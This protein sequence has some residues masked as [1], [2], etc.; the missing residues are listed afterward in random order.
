[1]IDDETLY[2]YLDGELDAADIARVEKAVAGDPGLAEKLAAQRAL[3]D[4]LKGAFDPIAEQPVPAAL[5]ASAAPAAAHVVDLAGVRRARTGAA[6]WDVRTWGA[7]AATL[8][9]GLIGGYAMHMMPAA[10]VTESD[11]RLVLS[12]PIARALDEQLASTGPSAGPVQVRLTF[13]DT[14]G[15]ICRSFEATSVSGVACRHDGRWTMR[16]LFEGSDT[17]AGP[18][19]TA[20]AADPALMEYVDGIIAGEPFDAASEARA[21]AQ[22]WTAT[23]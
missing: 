3:R 21:R 4:R 1:M 6:A 23:D 22:G 10:P 15:A 11:G 19:R 14:G 16:A 8:V 5:R 12:A 9:A 18:Y 13:R 17:G 7:I 20:G 2:A